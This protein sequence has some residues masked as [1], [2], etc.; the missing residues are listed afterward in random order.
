[1]NFSLANGGKD[2]F[3]ESYSL[4]GCPTY[5]PIDILT[6]MS[7]QNNKICFRYDSERSDIYSLAV[8]FLELI[9]LKLE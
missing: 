9:C 5:L 1:M 4:V 2:R 6:T 8:V 7:I 3:F